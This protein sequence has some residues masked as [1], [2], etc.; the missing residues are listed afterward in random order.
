[1][2]C[3]VGT[4]CLKISRKITSHKS[5]DLTLNK[6]N[7]TDVLIFNVTSIQY[8]PPFCTSRTAQSLRSVRSIST[9]K[10]S[11]LLPC[12]DRSGPNGA[13]RQQQRPATH[14]HDSVEIKNA[15]NYTSTPTRFLEK[16][17][18]YAQGYLPFA[19]HLCL[20]LP[21]DSPNNVHRECE[22][23]TG[24]KHFFT[25]TAR[26][27]S[28]HCAAGLPHSRPHPS[29]SVTVPMRGSCPGML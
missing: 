16:T 24:T 26:Q 15:R 7:P 13:K 4:N 22:L 8:S 28:A 9:V 14:L 17:F 6:L 5:L 21:C 19:S 10:V 12:P 23:S 1:V 27:P 18:N 20:H 29:M 11:P 25:F 3:L 2:W